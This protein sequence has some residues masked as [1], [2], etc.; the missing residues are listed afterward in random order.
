[1]SQPRSLSSSS[2]L[3]S[4]IFTLSS[5]RPYAKLSSSSFR[6]SAGRETEPEEEDIVVSSGISRPL[7]EIL[8]QLNK[9]VPD[10]VVK[11]RHENG[12]SS[13]YIPWYSFPFLLFSISVSSFF[14]QS[15]SY[16]FH[17]KFWLFGCLLCYSLMGISFTF[18]FVM[19]NSS[20]IFSCII[21]RVR[22]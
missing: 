15:F 16:F 19:T 22:S 13:K 3:K 9:K 2:L 7:S 1:M 14:P 8:Q 21:A 4:L 17:C 11:V 18:F 20:L 5:I 12:F 6:E 10:S